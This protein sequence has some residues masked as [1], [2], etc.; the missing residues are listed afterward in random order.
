MHH[1][2]SEGSLLSARFYVDPSRIDELNAISSANFDLAKLTKLCREL[3][4]CYQHECYLA[5]IMLVRAI[6]DHVPPIFGYRTFIEVANN[7][8]GQSLKKSLQNLQNSSRNIAN[9]YLHE[10][11]R[12]AESLPNATQVNFSNDLDVLLAEIGRVLK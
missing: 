11:I 1:G 6:L 5:A 4:V 7:Y 9:V 8:G 3:N 10:P 12:S 2:S